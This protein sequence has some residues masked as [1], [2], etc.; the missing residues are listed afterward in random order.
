MVSRARVALVTAARR[1]PAIGVA[2]ARARRPKHG[3]STEGMYTISRCVR[4]A[5]ESAVPELLMLGGASLICHSL[6]ALLRAG[7]EVV[8]LLVAHRG[9]EIVE[10][11]RTHF[12][13]KP[14]RFEF[15]SLGE[16]WR[17]T[18][19]MSLLMAH[20]TSVTRA[21]WIHARSLSLFPSPRERERERFSSRG[22]T[23]FSLSKRRDR[24]WRAAAA[25]RRPFWSSPRT[26]SSTRR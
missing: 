8:V 18:H 20:D 9:A 10:H 24:R 23:R 11:V 25:A 26:I 17:G 13:D 19:A 15:V 22:Q 16:G 7:V 3:I 4:Q 14:M 6:E 5:L 2:E 12:A 1:A 21:L